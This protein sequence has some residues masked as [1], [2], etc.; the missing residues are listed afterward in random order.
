LSITSPSSSSSMGVFVVGSHCLL[1]HDL[2]MQ[3]SRSAGLIAIIILVLMMHNDNC[4]Y[5]HLCFHSVLWL[6]LLLLLCYMFVVIST[7]E[8]VSVRRVSVRRVLWNLDLCLYL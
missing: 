8:F 1:L 7:N 3:R 2:R 5:V 6:L 4:L